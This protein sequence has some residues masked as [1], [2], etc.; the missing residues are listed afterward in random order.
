ME[1][2]LVLPFRR[3]NLLIAAGSSCDFAELLQERL[4]PFA[5]TTFGA[6]NFFSIAVEPAELA[7][8]WKAQPEHIK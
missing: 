7:M 3:S 6:V 4:A 1:Q 8:Q 5:L 2:A